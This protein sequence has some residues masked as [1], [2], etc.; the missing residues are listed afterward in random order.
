MIILAFALKGISL[1]LQKLYM[2]S[3]AEEVKKYSD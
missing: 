3:V 2:I 1:Y